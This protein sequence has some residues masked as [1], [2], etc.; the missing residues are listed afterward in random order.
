MLFRSSLFHY[1]ERHNRYSD[2]DSGVYLELRRQPLFQ[3]DPLHGPVRRKRILKRLW[4]RLPFRPLLR[5]LY[6]YMLRLGFLDGAAGLHFCLLASIHEYHIGVKV[7]EKLR[8]EEHPI[9]RLT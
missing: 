9:P 7:K 5:F 6:M 4:V 2:W 1:I 3:R 8:E